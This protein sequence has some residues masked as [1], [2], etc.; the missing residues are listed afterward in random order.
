MDTIYGKGWGCTECPEMSQTPL[1]PVSFIEVP[2]FE[3]LP[4]YE[5]FKREGLYLIRGCKEMDR[6]GVEGSG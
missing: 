2:G 5:E 6:N 1:I 3:Q 4:T